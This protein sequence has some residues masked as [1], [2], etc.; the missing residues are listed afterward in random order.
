[1]PINYKDDHFYKEWILKYGI[2]LNTYFNLI[3]YLDEIKQLYNPT[4]KRITQVNNISFYFL[5]GLFIFI[6]LSSYFS[7]SK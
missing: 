7:L 1:M 6:G 3:N 4:K 2:G 5:C